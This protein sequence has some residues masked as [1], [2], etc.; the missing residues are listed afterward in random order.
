MR[1]DPIWRR[2]KPDSF[3]TKLEGRFPHRF[4]RLDKLNNWGSLGWLYD[5]A[6]ATKQAHHYG[7]ERNAMQFLH[8]T[9]ERE[10]YRPSFRPAAHVM[11]WGHLP[12]SYAGAE[13]L[14]RAAHVDPRVQSV[15]DKLVDDVIAFGNLS[16]DASDHECAHAIRCGDNAFGLYR[17][18]SAWLVSKEWKK[19]W[20]AIKE[21]SDTTISETDVKS[22]LIRTL[23][24]RE[25]R[26]FKILSL[27]NQA[28]YVPRDL[29]QA[30]TA[31][32][33]FDIEALWE[34]NPLG[35]DAAGEWSLIEAAQ[36]YLDNRF[37]HVPESLLV[38][39]LCARAI[40]GGLVAGGVTSKSL[41]DL[42]KE[43]D[44]Y[45]TTKLSNYHRRRLDRVRSVVSSGRLREHWTLLG[46][47]TDVSLPGASRF[48]MEDHISARTGT[49][50]NSYPFSSGVSI[51]VDPGA[52]RLPDAFA[53]ASRRYA[54]VHVHHGI[55]D[56]G[57]LAAR[58]ILNVVAK[59]GD[60]LLPS[61]QIGDAVMSWLMAGTV[62]QRDAGIQRMCGDVAEACA[63][64]VKRSLAQIV[65]LKSFAPVLQHRVVNGVLAGFANPAV[66]MAE[67]HRF[68]IILLRLPWLALRS[69]GGRSLLRAL[70]AE[71]LTRAGTGSS[72]SRG[73]ALEL[74]V[75]AD[76]LLRDPIP[77]QRFVFVNPVL[78][79][80][81][82]QPTKEW[83]IIRLDLDTAKGWSLTAVECAVSRSA[84]KDTEGREKLELVRS[85][86][87]GRFSDLTTYST[88]FATVKDS[89]VSY[90]DAG[91]SWTALKAV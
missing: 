55:P 50:R 26:G 74:A 41:L 19:L 49:S 64:D 21:A 52:S 22:Q 85:V 33:T 53:G 5:H 82:G 1:F 77:S 46:S 13:G 32:L 8:G 31:W 11:H 43:G 67:Q 81:D 87:A 4:Q 61:P 57:A 17:W 42:T 18:I 65:R 56:K 40:A 86:V 78:I 25:S 63:D 24:C 38:H 72:S 60:H 34:G 3:T 35:A 51:V 69:S 59:L 15:V 71:A 84:S 29:L 80:K 30:G 54:T 16:C 89:D 76:Q 47:F 91:R 88:L 39:T 48:D 90:E 44:E 9:G 7:L 36:Q 2:V 62:E 28:D 45:Y 70:R 75:A 83:D 23:V 27:C 14:L 79:G 58:Q 68:A 6:R 12:L 66:S 20:K 10:K 37:F 73:Y